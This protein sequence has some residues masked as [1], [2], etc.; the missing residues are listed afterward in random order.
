MFSKETKFEAKKLKTWVAH[1]GPGY[2]CELLADGKKIASCSNDG[3]GGPDRIY[4]VS[5]EV[6]KDME[7]YLATFP[8]RKS[9]FGGE[10]AMDMEWFMAKMVDDVRDG[11]ALKRYVTARM[12]DLKTKTLMKFK[13]EPTYRTIKRPFSPTLLM[14]MRLSKWWGKVDFIFNQLSETEA[15]KRFEGIFQSMLIQDEDE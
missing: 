5:S 3:D 7:S 6:R 8:K 15:Q 13:N 9:Q 12:R 11:Q 14:Q 2:S 1:E 10:Y 4:F